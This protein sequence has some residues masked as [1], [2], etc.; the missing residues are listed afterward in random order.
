MSAASNYLENELLDHSLATGSFT[1]PSN[2]YVGLFTSADSTGATAANLEAGTI[3]DNLLHSVRLQADQ[4]Q[5]QATSLS[6]QV[7]ETGEQSLMWLF[8]MLQH[9]VMYCFMEH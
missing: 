7:A 9:Q 4:H 1:A 5:T 6:Q 8:T 3:T 2:V